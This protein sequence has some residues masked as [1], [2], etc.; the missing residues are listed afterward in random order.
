[1]NDSWN[2]SCSG[3]WNDETASNYDVG[4]SNCFTYTTIVSQ[5]CD[6]GGGLGGTP[7]TNP[8]TE[9]NCGT[10]GL[11]VEQ[12]VQEAVN[13]LCSRPCNSAPNHDGTTNRPECAFECPGSCQYNP[14]I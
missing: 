7:C 5:Y 1:M 14:Y 4:T 12:E 6:D 10:G 2:V 9:D 13:S 11:C 8:G 3:C